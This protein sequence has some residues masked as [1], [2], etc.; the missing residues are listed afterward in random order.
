MLAAF[1][2][3]TPGALI[4]EKT[5]SIAWHYRQCD[6]GLAN[7]RAAEISEALEAKATEAGLQLLDGDKVLELRNPAFNKGR[8]A[9]K[10]VAAGKYDF[11]LAIGD[12]TTDEDMFAA[13]PTGAVTIKVGTHV[14]AASYFVS[15]Y[16]EVRALLEGQLASGE[17][18]IQSSDIGLQIVGKAS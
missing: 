10:V 6:P 16:K 13:L 18:A 8:S 9:R 11:I 17:K 2:R 1:T 15:N 12:D 3:S 5:Y 4:E 7:R 14:T